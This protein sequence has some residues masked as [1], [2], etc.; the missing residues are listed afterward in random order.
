MANRKSRHLNREPLE[1]QVQRAVEELVGQDGTV[2]V[3]RSGFGILDS[4]LVQVTLRDAIP[5]DVTV[6]L[7]HKLRALLLEYFPRGSELHCSAVVEQF[8]EK[9]YPLH[10]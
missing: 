6:T 5:A 4:V 3:E 7:Q 2:Y 8:G 1:H 9:F 10:S